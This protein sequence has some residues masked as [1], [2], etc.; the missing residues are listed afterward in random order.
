[1][2]YISSYVFPTSEHTISTNMVCGISLG[3]HAA[4]QCLISDSR[5]TTAIVIIGCPDYITLMSDRA[6]LSKLS[7]WTSGSPPGSSFL[8]SVDFPKGLVEAVEKYDPAGLFLGECSG[9]NKDAYTREPSEEEKKR[10]LPLMKSSLQ[11][12]RILNLAGGADKLV[13]YKCGEPFLKWL[14]KSTAEEGWFGDGDFTIKDIVFEGVGHE[15]SPAMAKELNVFVAET[16]E[17]LPSE[18][19]GKTSKM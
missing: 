1:M 2:D 15:L 10:L 17:Q 18:P 13:P 3:G 11:G 4:W 14:K 6:R 16:L 19:S 12:K 7:T 8:E 5:I 9:H